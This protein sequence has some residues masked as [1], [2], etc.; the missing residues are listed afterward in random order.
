VGELLQ[1]R[2]CKASDPKQFLRDLADRLDEDFPSTEQVM[3]VIGYDIDK[4]NHD[5]GYTFAANDLRVRDCLWLLKMGELALLR[6]H[7]E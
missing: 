4:A 3:V 5:M 6:K 7:D 2:G 1:V